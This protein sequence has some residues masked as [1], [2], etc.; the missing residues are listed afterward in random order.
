MLRCPLCYNEKTSLFYRDK[1]RS[2]YNCHHCQLVFS[3]ANIHLPPQVEK[4]RYQRSASKYQKPLKHFLLSLIQQITQETEQSLIGLNFGRL[5][6][7]QTLN[8]IKAQGHDLRQYDPHFAPDHSLLKQQYDFISCYRVFEHFRSPFKEWSLLC[9]LLKPSAWLAINTKLLTKV[10]AFDRW[11]HKNNLTHV[12]F[13]QAE[14]FEF[15]AEQ[16][17]FRLLFAAN[18]LILVQKPSGSDIKRDRSSLIAL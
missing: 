14:T 16:A 12:S 15:L 4:K 18:D 9:K 1:K 11:H 7:T 13:Y 17:G 3:D 2:I 10:D 8:T 5:A 6:D